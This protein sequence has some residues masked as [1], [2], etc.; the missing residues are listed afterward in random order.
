VLETTRRQRRLAR[1]IFTAYA[2]AVAAVTVVPMPGH[3]TLWRHDPWWTTVVWVPGRV[4][5]W[6]FALNVL[7]FVPFGVLVPLI[8]RT[9]GSYLRIGLWALAASAAIEATQFVLDVTLGT[10]RAVDVNDLIA[11]TAGGLLGLVAARLAGLVDRRP[12]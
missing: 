10:H 3:R 8:W 1:P 11:N 7:M 2:L 12:G 5:A 4:P 6:S 9:A